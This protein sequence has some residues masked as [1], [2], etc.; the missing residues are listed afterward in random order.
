MPSRVAALLVVG[1]ILWLFRRQSKRTTPMSPGLWV[2]FIW[3]AIISSRPVGYWFADA[4]VAASADPMG[5]SFIDRNTYLILIVLGVIVLARR[6]INW[7]PLLAPGKCLWIFYAYLLISVVWSEFPF[8]AFK[9]WFKDFGNVVMILIILTEED[10]VEATR[11]IFVRCAYALISISVLFIKW[12]PDLGRY[13]H[14]W[15]WET[16]YC[17]IT[18]NKNSLGDIAM[19]SGL[20]LLWNIV[21]F[22]GYPKKGGRFKDVW[23]DLFVL[24]MCCWLLHK[25]QSAT[26]LTCFILGIFIFFFS[27][28]SWARN[29]LP[30]LG[31]FGLGVL[32]VMLAFTVVPEFRGAIAGV[33]GRDVTLTGRTDVWEA[34]L[35]LGTNPLLGSGFQ[36]TWLTEKGAA[37]AEELHVPHAHNGYLETYLHTGA[38]GVLLLLTVLYCAGRTAARNLVDGTI[39][40]NLFM[41]VFLSGVLYNYTE[42]AFNSGNIIGFALWLMAAL[43]GSL[44]DKIEV[45]DHENEPSELNAELHLDADEVPAVG[46]T[47]I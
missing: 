14:K 6:R 34:A 3:L 43:N 9:R 30:R 18:T 35:N 42:V 46:G 21:D 31:L 1:F 24:G 28:L 17:G 12:F 16:I 19:M 41:A 2:A 15:T 22:E 20:L 36:S 38:I 40:G 25:A 23:P 37:M 7:G 39:S 4:G 13:Y 47:G 32:L 26:S 8:I 27:R 5:G 44:F 29:N 10:P 45:A 11:A 33:L